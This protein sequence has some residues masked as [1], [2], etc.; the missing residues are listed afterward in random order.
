MD[1]AHERIQTIFERSIT[2]V[3]REKM[4]AKPVQQ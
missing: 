2:Q 1:Q 3:L 4:D